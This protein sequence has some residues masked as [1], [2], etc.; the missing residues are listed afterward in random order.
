[1]F[2]VFSEALDPCFIFH[3][4]SCSSPCN[5]HQQ[6]RRVHTV[7]IPPSFAGSCSSPSSTVRSM[8]AQQGESLLFLYPLPSPHMNPIAP[9]S[10]PF[11]PSITLQFLS[12]SPS[13]HFLH[14]T[15]FLLELLQTV[16][17]AQHHYGWSISYHTPFNFIPF[18]H[19][20]SQT[21]T[22]LLA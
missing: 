22:I 5:V 8:N 9:H 11:H 17:L 19:S 7:H 20:Y 2:R 15:D 10:P 21:Y 18:F 14:P 6:G 4:L 1:M 12:F 13:N 16:S 3:A